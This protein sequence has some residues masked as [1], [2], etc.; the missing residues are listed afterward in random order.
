[1][2]TRSRGFTLLEILIA[3]A[4]FA[5]LAVM[6]YSGLSSV[7]R[8]REITDARADALNQLVMANRLLARDLEQVVP[9]PIRDEYGDTQ[10]P[11]LGGSTIGRI[12]ELTRGG[13]RNPAGQLRSTLQRVAYR[14]D[15]ESLIREYWV[16]LDRAQE[17]EPLEQT[18]LDGVQSVT[19]RF[20]D[21]KQTWHTE[22]PPLGL[23][24]ADNAGE[25]NLPLA[26]EVTLEI[27]GW[28]EIRWLFRMPANLSPASAASP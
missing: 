22:W 6:A 18:L 7:L 14:V 13:W 24:E 3:L 5:L 12:I 9:R 28:G 23:N 4:I 27:E 19:L 25:L 15:E 1:M 16:T 20:L 8:T 17:S 26:T 11:L 2:I 21:D 10:P